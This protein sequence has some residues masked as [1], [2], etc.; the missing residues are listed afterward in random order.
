MS[1]SPSRHP[2]FVDHSLNKSSEGVRVY[3]APDANILLSVVDHALPS[4]DY[5]NVIVAGKQPTFGSWGWAGRRWSGVLA[6]D[7]RA[8]ENYRVSFLVL[9]AE[10]CT[11][12]RP[13][14][15]RT[16]SCS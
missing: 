1:A 10:L 11:T 6:G 16:R 9:R 5:V 7:G 14:A 12:L 3:L 2:G 15:R 13:A 4:R 8:G